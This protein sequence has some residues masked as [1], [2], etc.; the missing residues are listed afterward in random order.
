MFKKEDRRW[1]DKWWAAVNTAMNLRSTN[2]GDF[3]D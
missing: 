1:L 3:F 2:R